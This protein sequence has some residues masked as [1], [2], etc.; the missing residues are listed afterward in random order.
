M[1]A[2]PFSRH[3]A[4]QGAKSFLWV[5]THAPNGRAGWPVMRSPVLVTGAGSPG[6]RLGAP[7]A[8]R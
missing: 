6:A 2:S 1:T 4:R 8:G 7:E 5:R 3:G